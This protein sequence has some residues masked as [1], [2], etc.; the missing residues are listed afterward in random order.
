MKT[1]IY[2]TVAHLLKPTFLKTSLARLRALLLCF[3]A[4]AL[5][6][7]SVPQA[8]AVSAFDTTGTTGSGAAVD[9]TNPN[10]GVQWVIA[11]YGVFPARD[12]GPL[13][14]GYDGTMIGEIRCLAFDA[15]VGSI[16]SQFLP[17]DGRLLS[18]AQNTA[19][20][21]LLGTAYGGN[22]TTN[23]AIPDLRGRV[24]M[25]TSA[26]YL[27]GS[28]VGAE[29]VTLNVTQL[30]GHTHTVPGGTTSSTGGGQA[31]FNQQPCL[32]LTIGTQG[33]GIFTSMGW[34]RI[35]GFNFLPPGFYRGTGGLE[36]I[37]NNEALYAKLGTT[38][39]GDGVTTFGLPDFQG[40]TLIG[41]GQGGGLTN[42]VLGQTGGT[43]SVTLN[44]TQIPA[45]SHT[46]TGGNT[47]STGGGQ[48][49][50]KVQPFIVLNPAI[51][52]QG[53]FAGSDEDPSIGELR[54]FACSALDQR[55]AAAIGT[56]L[57]I[58][59]NAALFS[60]LGTNYG[61]NGT[62]NFNIP[63]LRGRSLAGVG[64]GPGLPQRA[65]GNTW[66]G[67][68]MTLS[69]AQLP[70]HTHTYTATAQPPAPTISGV[71]P[72]SGTTAGGTSVTIS[73]AN[74]TG[75]S[76]VTFGGNAAAVTAST[77]TSL[78]VT[79]PAHA[80]GAVDVVVTTPG[81]VVTGTNAF[82]YNAP[83]VP[84]TIDK[85]RAAVTVAEG[86][87]ALNSGTFGGQVGDTITLTA[88]T[89]TVSQTASGVWAFQ[90]AIA[91]ADNVGDPKLDAAGNLYINTDAGY[92]VKITPAGVQSQFVF[93]YQSGGILVDSATNTLYVSALAE[94]GVS[95]G[96]AGYI[97][98]YR[99]D[100]FALISRFAGPGSGDG[101]LSSPYNLAKDAAG[102]LYVSDS[103]NNRVQ[104]FTAAG[105]FLRKW[106]SL[107]TGDGQFNFPAGMQI[108]A[109]GTLFIADRNN[110]RVQYFTTAGAF[111]GKWGTSGTG[112]G[113]FNQP[114]SVD[115]D[116][117]GNIFVC[118]LANNRVQKFDAAGVFL[119]KFGPGAGAG[120]LSFPDGIAFVDQGRSL[121][122]VNYSAHN[123][124]KYST[125][126]TWS[127]SAAGTD[128]PAG[129]TTVTITATDSTN[130]TSTQ[131]TFPFTVNNVAPT[132]A[133]TG[134]ATAG[135]GVAYT[136]N[137]GA[138]SD[139]GTD[140]VTGY[141]IAWG[142]GVTEPF[143]GVPSGSKTHS[144][145]AVGAQTITVSLTD[146]DGTFAGAGTL[147]L[148]VLDA[149]A[150]DTT[151]TSAP[152]SLVNSRAASIAFSGTD[153]VAVTGFE[154][155]LDGASY[156]AATSPASLTGLGDGSHT[157]SVRAKDAAGNVD[158]TPASVTWT[159]DAT[160]PETT[161][162]SAP[163]GT[164]TSTTAVITFTGTDGFALA[165]VAAFNAGPSGSG[166]ASFEAS[167]D[168]AL[169]SAATSPVNLTG[170]TVGAHTFR[171]RAVD[172][173]GN[174]DATPASATWTVAAAMTVSANGTYTIQAGNPLVLT[175]TGTPSVL[176]NPIT[177]SWTI[178]G[179]TNA[180]TGAN[181]TVTWAQLK[182]LGVTGPVASVAV[183]VTG[184]EYAAGVSSPPAYYPTGTQLNV[185]I[186]TILAGGWALGYSDLYANPME[187]APVL[188]SATGGY[189]MLA[190]RAVGSNTVLLLGAAPRADVT[191]DTGHTNTTHLANGV[192]WYFS[193]N[194]SWG[195]AE[196]NDAVIRNEADVNGSPN[197][198]RRL[199]WHTGIGAGGYRIGALTGLN[200][201]TAYER[202]V[203]QADGGV[204]VA[205]ASDATTLAV[206]AGGSIAVDLE[207]V[208]TSGTG[209]AVDFGVVAVNGSSR[210]TLVVA[211]HGAAPLTISDITVPTGYRIAAG[212]GSGGSGS[213]VVVGS[214]SAS[215]SA[216]GSGALFP[217]TIAAGADKFFDVFFEPV[218]SGTYTGNL[219]IVS[220]DPGTVPFLVPVTGRTP[221]PL[222]T[223]VHNIETTLDEGLDQIPVYD[224]G[225]VGVGSTATHTFTIFNH[226]DGPMNV[227]SINIYDN[228][229][230]QL[231]G[232][233]ALIN[234]NDYAISGVTLP[235][236]IPINGS[237]TFDV[238]FQ[239][240]SV[241]QKD[242]F[243]EIASDASNYA[244]FQFPVTGNGVSLTQA[245]ADAVTLTTG[246]TRIYPLANDTGAP[247]NTRIIRA[248]G[249][250]GVIISADGR[251]LLIP[252]D[253]SGT[254][255]Y[256]TNIGTT[257]QIAVTAR[258]PSARLQW[259]GL[260]YDAEGGVAGWMQTNSSATGRCSVQIKMGSNTSRGLFNLIG[261]KTD[262]PVP[263]TP[264]IGQ[265][266]ATQDSDGHLIV[267]IQSRSTL[268]GDLRPTASSATPRQY[269]V[270]LA[271]TD[272]VTIPGG[273]ILRAIVKSTGGVNYLSTLPDGT[274]M[275]GRSQLLDNDTMLIYHPLTKLSPRGIVTGG[276]TLA[277]LPTTDI[278]GEL[279]WY[280]PAQ[281]GGLNAAGF[282]T[283][284][285][286]NGCIYAPG[287]SLISGPVELDITGGD[288]PV[289]L[290]STTTASG[291]RPTLTPLIR[292]WNVDTTRGTF[293]SFLYTPI[294][295]S[296]INCSGIYLPKS[297][298]AWGYFK[299][300]TVGG[301]LDMHPITR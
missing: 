216:S 183:S 267:T 91:L 275:W 258:R 166:V 26:A 277:N 35:F 195:F 116:P 253:A 73:G 40:R 211:N 61:G 106:G 105:A 140:T 160:A 118:D 18:I 25:G 213:V 94:H 127:W 163:T 44:T 120:L 251:S 186:A 159:V 29:Q 98:K 38:Y 262:I 184:K 24:P 228:S 283:L 203:F 245:E 48:A 274:A 223:V 66:G 218:E 89:G 248:S 86:T 28:V 3:V 145:T 5:A 108:S 288:L 290:I 239:P 227:S 12:G 22:G 242:W 107:G 132:I 13:D 270:A 182:A 169:F 122:I 291:G 289:E 193:S 110:N 99:L 153:N 158:A 2:S 252:S 293:R 278:T 90:Q 189:L 220:N 243:V 103:G 217:L 229:Q 111:L 279:K 296:R 64:T 69:V 119:D 21:S 241:G 209:A 83:A 143:S 4:V 43:T 224:F 136:L 15:N 300:N 6:C 188:A 298:S 154:A 260:I 60:L 113:Q 214:G 49:F 180:A 171:V 125:P 57:P 155:S 231:S 247:A 74:F 41:Q 178:N 53:I 199:S 77:A 62:S 42:R 232:V 131:V 150:P 207:G 63:D 45:H 101:Q 130:S 37:V 197:A 10:L 192:G 81:G 100:T 67:E 152:A 11:K 161:I 219:S 261:T 36:Q 237:I 235:A 23:F 167:L 185:P 268:T 282:D 117:S 249:A 82:T 20:F 144:Y 114:V 257:A 284:L 272:S 27:L 234:T 46:I 33:S 134:N 97:Y 187:T 70:A 299:G 104:A 236:V 198:D 173:A 266:T 58:Q 1:Q 280:K 59:Q 265:V 76:A 202:L 256:T 50:S 68:T 54:L 226:G 295:S 179:V 244:T 149:T 200:G 240:Q 124:V 285:T 133:L 139:P 151:I 206:T 176:G 177:Y 174:V 32:A 230:I 286:A 142:D 162:T 215:G 297:Q 233:A 212:V 168:G 126:G 250:S 273:G 85:D 246:Y 156:S 191:F 175:A 165:G 141:S 17:C 8:V 208:R 129:P 157:F 109:G 128:G 204:V 269:N 196:G 294:R 30:P 123:V 170:L 301:R 96:N 80:V 51:A 172:V 87:T 95:S 137:L 225:D 14:G 78:T 16:P 238:V 287:M 88:S 92:I 146:E 65:L 56:T 138:I 190:A 75:V 112:N 194:W 121:Y 221:Q 148:T 93:G 276:F 292:T 135:S 271:S 147:G 254:I 164:T 19:L 47:G 79:S 55:Y 259:I 281:A 201:S 7:F 9:T 102:N 205:T 39:G 263:M 115:I 255:T 71:S 84:P 181:P 31:I 52:T 34:V 210:Y 264:P 222:I 72:N